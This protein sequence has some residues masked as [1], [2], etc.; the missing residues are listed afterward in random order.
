[1]I[2]GRVVSGLFCMFLLQPA[3][4]AT[5]HKLT[6]NELRKS[7]SS[8]LSPGLVQIQSLTEPKFDG[9]YVDARAFDADAIF[10][11]APVLLPSGRLARI[12]V[13]GANGKRVAST[14]PV[15]RQLRAAAHS[16][17]KNRHKFDCGFQKRIGNGNAGDN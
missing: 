15:A 7:V 11:R 10:F 9:Q 6:Q 3:S 1:M 5:L 14:S 2:F 13:D 12:V 16:N 4:G 17:S 8:G